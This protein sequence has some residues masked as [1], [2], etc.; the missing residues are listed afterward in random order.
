MIEVR[1]LIFDV[2]NFRLG[3]LNVSIKEGEYFVLLGRPG[4]GKTLLL[5]CLAGLRR[6]SSGALLINGQDVTQVEPRK[7]GL[8][9][10]P[11]DYALFPHLS[12]RDN[13]EFGLKARGVSA[14][15]KVSS[16]CEMLNIS[17]ILNRGI[18][19]LSG[20]ERQRVSLARALV[21]DPHV[22]LLDEPV[23]A[24]DEEMRE[25]TCLEIQ[26]IH[27]ET[28]TTV[29]HICHN[30][31]ETRLMADRVG[32]LRDGKLVQVGALDELYQEPE[33]VDVARF[34]RVK[35]IYEGVIED[36]SSKQTTLKTP[37]GQIK[38]KGEFSHGSNVHFE[39][40]APAIKLNKSAGAGQQEDD[41]NPG[42]TIKGKVVNSIPRALHVEYVVSVG[43]SALIHVFAQ[44]SDVATLEKGDQ[45]ELFFPPEAVKIFV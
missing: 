44:Q 43:S 1:D 25:R 28:N 20:G 30:I 11:Q 15:E 27:R 17:Y 31:E 22:L 32:I 9:Y 40:T 34:L 37:L 45:L 16:V 19:G 23:S 42:N 18:Q 7:R 14:T 39:V 24:L 35:N 36:S 4:S 21:L 41:A 10:V 2:G 13:I 3:P 29:V 6:A 33:D 26:R 5:E 12:V 8:G 38:C